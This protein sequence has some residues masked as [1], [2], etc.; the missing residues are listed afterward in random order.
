MTGA[1]FVT[2]PDLNL[3]LVEELSDP[4]P[5]NQLLKSDTMVLI[6][7]MTTEII[8]LNNISDA[9]ELIRRLQMVPSVRLSD[10]DAYNFYDGLIGLLKFVSLT[11][12]KRRELRSLLNQS[13]V[14]A[15]EA[16]VEV[17]ANLDSFINL[18]EEGLGTDKEMRRELL[19]ALET[20]RET[21]GNSMIEVSQNGKMEPI[22][23]NW[24]KSYNL[25]QSLNV[26]RGRFNQINFLNSG[27]NVGLLS[28]TDKEVLSEL[29]RIYDK[30]LFPP[31]GPEVVSD[32][33]VEEREALNQ[34]NFVRSERFNLPKEFLSP[35][36]SG[37]DGLITG[38]RVSKTPKLPPKVPMPQN[39]AAVKKVDMGEILAGQEVKDKR[40]E[41]STA[42]QQTES[43]KQEAE[44]ENTGA[45]L[46]L[47]AAPPPAILKKPISAPLVTAETLAAQMEKKKKGREAEIDQ[48]LHKLEDRAKKRS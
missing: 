35:Q 8:R 34:L 36:E 4:I 30:L 7:N 10:A 45:G 3:P 42:E 32:N 15:L 48:K 44:F 5:L 6:Q 26:A 19:Y 40:P 21:L 38:M 23:Q 43:G 29:I 25:S 13:L 28:S 16:G 41:T 2:V 14:Q 46:Q 24:L 22:V 1:N 9:L 33:S 18:Y 11:A 47:R 20:N 31:P 17:S 12:C 27:R 37:N 39:R